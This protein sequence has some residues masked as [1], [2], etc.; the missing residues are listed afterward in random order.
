MQNIYKIYEEYSKVLLEIKKGLISN[1]RVCIPNT[2]LRLLV[3][4][5]RIC[6]LNMQ[7]S[8]WHSG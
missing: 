5:I 1:G 4:P 3:C 7:Y 6:P 8:R 2:N